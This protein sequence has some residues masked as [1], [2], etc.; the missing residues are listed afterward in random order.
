MQG[1]SSRQRSGLASAAGDS[2]AD[3][4]RPGPACGSGSGAGAAA[5]WLRQVA[6]AL[7][8]VRVAG[9]R[10]RSGQQHAWR[11]VARVGRRPNRAPQM[12]A[13]RSQPVRWAAAILRA[14]CDPSCHGVPPCRIALLPV[15][16]VPTRACCARCGS[17][18]WP[19]WPWCWS[20]RPRAQQR[21]D[22]LVAAVVG[23]HA[24][25]GM[26]EPAPVRPA[27]FSSA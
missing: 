10:R 5:G 25:A 15:P 17:S 27:V 14:C 11:P 12:P 19:G 26:V 6:S 24:D 23:R 1:A 4:G 16:N 9:R 13:S 21:V 22:R 3:A 8:R 7:C 2:A 20:G 18:P